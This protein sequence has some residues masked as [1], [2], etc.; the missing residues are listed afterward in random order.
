MWMRHEKS[1]T[2]TIRCESNDRSKMRA[3]SVGKMHRKV[4]LMS[5][6]TKFEEFELKEAW[7]LRQMGIY[8]IRE[9]CLA[10]GHPESDRFDLKDELQRWLDAKN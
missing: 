6:K 1:S 4:I 3:A 7:R 8:T 10:I 5:N 9:I 2:A